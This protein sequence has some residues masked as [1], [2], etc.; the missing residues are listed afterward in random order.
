[1]SHDVQIGATQVTLAQLN[2]RSRE[3]F[4]QIVESY[5]A[6]GEPVGSRNL[7]RL[8]PMTLSPA[9]VRNVMSDLEQLGLIFAPHTSAGRLPTELGLRFFVDALMEIGDLTEQDRRAIEA[10]A[11]AAS[12]GAKSIDAILNE[13]SGLLSGLTRAAGVVLTDKSNIRLKHIEFVRLEPERAL[14]VMVAEDGQIENRVLNLP[15]GLP[16]SALTEATNFFNAHIRGRTL[17]EAKADLER[18]LAAGQ[19]E[20]DQLTQKIVAAGLASWSGGEDPERRLIV[21]GHANLLEDLKALQDLERVRLLF[22]DLETKRGLA[23]ILGRAERA[24]GVRIFIGSENKLFSLSGSSTIV[25]PY[26]DGADRIVGV[27]GVIGPTR[28]NYARIIPMVDYTA[29]VVSRL[30]AGPAA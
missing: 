30:L 8:I 13:A 9:S 20:L 22:D 23:D 6:T 25:A 18:A 4:R 14:V 1:M 11:A 21:R 24:E 7:A 19:A 12:G 15:L 17:S 26:R 2:E 16:T 28:L 3:I 10:Q 29:K 5:L 27:L